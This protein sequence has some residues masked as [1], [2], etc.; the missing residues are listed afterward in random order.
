MEVTIQR[1]WE[2]CASVW[3]RMEELGLWERKDSHEDM[4]LSTKQ[5]NAVAA[6]SETKSRNRAVWFI[7]RVRTFYVSMEV[8]VFATGF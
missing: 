1:L 6:N 7:C 4:R 2:L 3:R 5:T 8:R